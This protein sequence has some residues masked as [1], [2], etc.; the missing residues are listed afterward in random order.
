MPDMEIARKL[1]GICQSLTPPEK[2]GNVVEFLT[3]TENAQ[4]ING[5]VEDIHEA[6][7]EYQV[8]TLKDPFST[9]SH[10]HVRLHYNKISTMR[11]VSTLWVLLSL[12][13]VIKY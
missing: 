3:N 8:C 13:V 11:V 9:I 5:V 2:Q 4:R 7:M 6:F 1:E 10:L 12:H